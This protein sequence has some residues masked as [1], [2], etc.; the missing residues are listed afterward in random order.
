[1]KKILIAAAAATAFISTA[2]WAAVSYDPE[3]GGFVG[4]GDVQIAFG[5]NNAKFQANSPNVSFSYEDAT[6]Y[7]GVCDWLTG[8]KLHTKTVIVTTGINATVVKDQRKNS[9]L[10]GW[11][12]EPVGSS[13]TTE[14]I[15]EVG[16]ECDAEGSNNKGTYTSVTEISTGGA[17]LQAHYGLQTVA[18]P[19]TL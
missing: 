2:A 12:L 11:D 3:V 8:K 16:G 6:T 10:L 13:I 5:W 18:L 9:Q 17:G 4:K 15:P 1:M 14:D 19:N 7:E